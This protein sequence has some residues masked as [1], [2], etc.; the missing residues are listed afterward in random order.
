MFT[1]S[2]QIDLHNRAVF[3][4]KGGGSS[5]TAATPLAPTVLTDPVS[6][7]SFT[8][9]ND[10]TS[11]AYDASAP[12][13]ADQLNAEITQRK[14]D[15][16]A[17][18][19]KTTATAAQTAA[20]N[21]Q[22]FQAN[23]LT[24]YNDAIV[25]AQDAFR[26]QGVDPALYTSEIANAINR[27]N[28]SIPDLDANPASAFPTN[29]GDTIVSDALSGKRTQTSNALNNIFTPNYSTTALPDSIT[30]GYVD[31]ILNTQFDPLSAQLT[32]AQRRGTLTDAGYQA[33]VD[34]LSQKRTAAASTVQNLG[35]GILASD[36]KN[37]DDYISG[38]RTDVNNMSLGSNIDPTTYGATAQGK[39]DTDKTSFGGALQNAVGETKFADITDLLNTGGAVQG[40][41]NPS[42]A[43]PNGTSTGNL[44]PSFVSEDELS[45]RGRGLGNTGAF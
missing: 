12:S 36:R 27:Q 34:R 22:K 7:K 23:K 18:S 30:S 1:P 11:S 40:G 42:A 38:A 24:A 43:N 39:V 32:N 16:Q 25:S 35:Q 37:L 4:G 5:Y 6:G 45:K 3:G 15:E 29:L 41:T 21:E 31:N 28:N 13:A 44:S 26:R 17:A 10:T 2:G 19:D 20:E 8:Q 14:A 9:I 33:A